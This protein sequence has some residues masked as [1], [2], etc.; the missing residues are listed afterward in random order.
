MLLDFQGGQAPEGKNYA[1][2]QH[3]GN[4][5]RRISFISWK[6]IPGVYRD[7]MSKDYFEVPSMKE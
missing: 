5:V 3:K 2:V 1:L 6:S 4:Y 7:I